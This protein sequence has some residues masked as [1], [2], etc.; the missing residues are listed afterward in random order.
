MRSF[1]RRKMEAIEEKKRDCQSFCAE[2]K[3]SP[4]N[5]GELARRHRGKR[6]SQEKKSPYSKK[7]VR[8]AG[9]LETWCHTLSRGAINL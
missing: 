9:A 8:K 5:F 3:R 7:I 6:V 4:K 1:A 2:Q